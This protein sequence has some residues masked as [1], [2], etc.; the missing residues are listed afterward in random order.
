MKKYNYYY[1]KVFK[2]FKWSWI[3]AYSALINHTSADGFSVS[4]CILL[5]NMLLIQS[6]E[7]F[8]YI[9]NEHEYNLVMQ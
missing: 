1:L 4:T 6:T 3:N 5:T 9:I 8:Q 2:N 7:S